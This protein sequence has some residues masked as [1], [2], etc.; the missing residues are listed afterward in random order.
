V[1]DHSA[2]S[3]FLGGWYTSIFVCLSNMNICKPIDSEL[4]LYAYR[5]GASSVRVTSFQQV[6]IDRESPLRERP[7]RSV[8]YTQIFS[9]GLYS[10]M[11]LSLT[12]QYC[13]K[14][15]PWYVD[16]TYKSLGY[17]SLDQYVWVSLVRLNGSYT[18]VWHISYESLWYVSMVATR[19]C[20]TSRMSLF[21]TSRMSL[22]GTSRW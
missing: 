17:V 16:G 15:A 1:F 18:S 14:K 8:L 6:P 20:D 4:H 3:P 2:I 5:L 12:G 10:W 11:H 22:F 7:L 9:T 19:L 13:W 21:G